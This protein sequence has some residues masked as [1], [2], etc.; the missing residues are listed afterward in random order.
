L[1]FAPAIIALGALHRLTLPF[2]LSPRA[3]ALRLRA[4]PF[5]LSLGA[6]ALHPRALPLGLSRRTLALDARFAA[7]AALRAALAALAAALGDL[8]ASIVGPCKSGAQRGQDRCC[9]QQPSEHLLH[10]V[11]PI[12]VPH[13]E[14]ASRDD[15][16]IPTRCKMSRF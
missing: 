1:L 2:G 6:L 11:S 13:T 8:D 3:F 9:H 10:V 14:G 7:A 15:G 16:A 5:G 12:R 4:L